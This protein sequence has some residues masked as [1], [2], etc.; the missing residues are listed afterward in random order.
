MRYNNE[1]KKGQRR[2]KKEG[3]TNY[4][5]RKIYVLRARTLFEFLMGMG[6]LFHKRNVAMEKALSPARDLWTTRVASSEE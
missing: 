2:Q 6:R 1:R 3:Q 5:L 4:D